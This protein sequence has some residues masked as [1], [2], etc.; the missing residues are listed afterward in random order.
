T[1][2]IG[3]GL[4]FHFAG[5]K[6]EQSV[7]DADTDIAAGMPFRAALSYENHP[8]EHALAAEFLHAEAA[9][10]RVA[11]VARRTARFLVGHDRKTPN[12]SLKRLKRRKAALL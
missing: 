3:L 2:T 12:A 8:A 9:P 10:F 7:V 1:T 5:R 11:P 4:K 6:G